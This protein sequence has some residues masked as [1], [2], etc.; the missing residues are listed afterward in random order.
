MKFSL[1]DKSLRILILG[2]TTLGQV[3]C[4][5][6][7]PEPH[8]R[9]LWT[10][11]THGYLSPLYHREEGDNLF[12][13]RARTQGRAGGFAHIATLVKRQRK[14][15][16]D[17]TLLVDSGDTW[18]GTV[19]PVRLA[20]TPVVEVMNAMGYDAMV[21]G[22]VDFFYNEETIHR[23]HSAA[24]FPIL[25][26]NIYDQHWGERAAIPNTSPYVVRTVN[27][28]KV[29]I[30]GMT[31]HW[32]ARVTDHPQWSFG[33][34]V[35]EIQDDI[36]RLRND[37]DV[38]IV[39]MLSHMGWKADTRYAEL[40]AG[41]DVIVGAHTHDTLYKPTLVFNSRSNRS[42]IIVQS[43]SHGKYLGQLDLEVR[44]KRVTAFHQTLFPV[45]ADSVR[46]DPEIA[47]MIHAIREPYEKELQRVIAETTTLLYR[48]GTW[49][50]TADNLIT[51]ALR[52]R[53]MQDVSIAQ[54]GRYGA[55]VL[56]GNITVEDI[57]NL[58]PTESPVYL[59]S[60]TGADLRRM[61]ED[62]IDN[63]IS[64]DPLQQI[65]GYMWRFSGIEIAVDFGR[66]HPE[67]IVSMKVGTEIIHD[68]RQYSL[69]EFNMFFRNSPDAIDVRKTGKIGPQEIIAYVEKQK[70]VS[71]VL[72]H[73][74]TDHHGTILGDHTDLHNI[75]QQTG[76]N[77]VELSNPVNY[78]YHGRLDRNNRLQL[79][80]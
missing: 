53:T 70:T 59:M 23:L 47:G 12:V 19:I 76:R 62:A 40:V 69:A 21:P 71:P 3:A 41:I 55:S 17:R 11:D 18:H 27:G 56:P 72:D 20:G 54:P 38:D 44:D 58:V 13:D 4:T 7:I 33:L 5:H 10:N 25:I 49:Q 45:L 29:G 30:I 50:S 64:A 73:R 24:N 1:D 34:R 60:F 65:G 28:L 78:R 14:Q 37:E 43:G 52:A 32:M 48:S 57:Y 51:D 46:E 63:V 68:A 6:M 35:S 16:P 8:L 42:V 39:I 26:A 75:N 80:R 9:I 74:I 22:N 31:Y 77:E 2:L 61:F 36:D 15:F 79:T 67:R 66:P